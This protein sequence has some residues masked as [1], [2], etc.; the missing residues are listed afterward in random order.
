LTDSFA[1]LF[2][3]EQFGIKLGLENITTILDALDHPERA[4]KTIHIAGTNGKG[5]VTAMIDSVL[6]AAGYRSGRFTSPHLVDV[7]ERFAVDGQPIDRATLESVLDELRGVIDRLRATG[8]LDVQPT[9]FEVTT[10]AA[11]EIF[12]RAKV[13]VAVCEV[14]LGGRL[15]A[16][17]VLAPLVTAVTT[18]GLDHQRY[19]GDTLE[20]IALEKAGIIKPG[21][22]VVVG[23]MDAAAH[24]VI[25]R[26]AVERNAPLL[27]AGPER[28]PAV[29][30]GLAGDHQIG[31]AAVAVGVLEVLNT[32]SVR[33]PAEAIRE[34]LSNVSWAGRL[35]LR[36]LPDGRDAL[37]DAAHN[38]DG[39]AA[40]AAFLTSKSMTRL[41]LVFGVMRDKDIDAILATLLPSVSALV[42]T[43]ASTPRSADPSEL[44]AAARRVAGDAIPIQ[45]I[46]SPSEA[47]E[48]AWR[49]SSRIVVAGSIFLL[50]DVMK[51]FGWG[52]TP[53]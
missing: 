40:L 1:W 41:P 16:T 25:R 15:D 34:G 38:R 32:R 27:D 28:V 12:R 45:V 39:A 26:V 2:G 7:T 42:A 20:A 49:R 13:D 29:H 43:R 19:L 24:D 21:V 22:P 51:E 47:M 4:Y 9:F 10:A 50:G 48:A 30:L 46:A 11:F 14:G 36:R 37:L 5:S 23:R 6:R 53:R 35:D 3:L 8:A 52:Q 33:I 18:I 17:N 44:A 31:N